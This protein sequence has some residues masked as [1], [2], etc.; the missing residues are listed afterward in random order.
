M[1]LTWNARVILNIP[2]VNKWTSMNIFHH[3]S[4]KWKFDFPLKGAITYN[5]SVEKSILRE[6]KNIERGNTFGKRTVLIRSR[7]SIAYISIQCTQESNYVTLYIDVCIYIYRWN[8]ET[9]LVKLSTQSRWHKEAKVSDRENKIA[10]FPEIP[11]NPIPGFHSFIFFRET[12][13]SLIRFD[14]KRNKASR[15]R[16]EESQRQYLPGPMFGI[17]FAKGW[18][19]VSRNP[20]KPHQ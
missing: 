12:E 3:L 18:H 17:L 7:S 19:V 20:L 11:E 10:P 15:V 5:R 14:A 8:R 2:S 6:G 13:K 16:G 9:K 4:R 1:L